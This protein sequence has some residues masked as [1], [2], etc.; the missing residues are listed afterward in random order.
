M[1]TPF[2]GSLH[3]IIKSAHQVDILHKRTP[4]TELIIFLKN[5]NLKMMVTSAAQ[6]VN[7]LN[8]SYY[9]LPL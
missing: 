7:S 8:V 2:A 1:L 3:N 5:C 6:S 4:T 9:I